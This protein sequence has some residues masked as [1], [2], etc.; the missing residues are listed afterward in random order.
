MSRTGPGGPGRVLGVVAGALAITAVAA[1]AAL[2]GLALG[3]PPAPAQETGEAGAVEEILSYDVRVEVGAGGAL[4]VTEALEVRALGRQIRRGIYR[5][6]PTRF[7][8]E[9]GFGTVVAPFR[10]VAV[11]RDG[12][13]ERHRLESVEGPA[14]RSGVRIRVGREDVQLSR[15]VHEYRIVYETARWL[16]FGPE[17]DRLEWNVTGNGWAFPIREASAAVELPGSPPADGVELAAWT[18]PAGSREQDAAWGWDAGQGRARFRTTAP[19]DAREGLT[20]RVDV[21][22][23]VIP[24][25]SEAQRAAWFRLDWGGF[26]DAALV[27]G[28]LLAFYLLM[29]IRVGRDPASRATVVRYEPPDGFSA[30]AAGFLRERGFD[31][32]QATAAVVSLAVKGAVTIERDGRKWRIRDTGRSPDGLTPDEEA[33]RRE[34]LDSSGRIVLEGAPSERVRKAVN[35]LRKRLRR[36]LEKEY[37]LNNRGWFAAG[38][39]VSLAG[40]GALGW[41]YRFGVGPEGWF[42]VLWL[43]FWTIG[44]AALLVRAFQAWR[45]ALTSG[46]LDWVGAIFLTGF[47]VPFVGAELVVGGMLYRLMPGHVVAA[48]IVVGALNVLFY[49]LLERPT[50][51]GRGVLDRLE[52]FRRFLGATEEGRMNRLQRPDRSLELFERFLPYAIAL[53]VQN[54]WAARFEGAVAAGTTTPS[55]YGGGGISGPAGVSSA[56]GGSL[57]SSLSASSASPSSGGGGAGGSSGGGGGGGGGGGW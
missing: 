26:R 51:K 46:G 37:F 44:V 6:F 9:E 5:D 39:A 28:L 18:G 3:A 29:W 45:R 25:P 16:R 49:H 12:R 20:V 21:P 36:R 33:L 13:P 50:M 40:L 34:L 32:A 23:G 52:G 38:L 43:A 10:V 24:P 42:L 54:E 57:S 1:L 14:G 2:A 35:K 53:G 8:R 11:E 55:W 15:G 22:S 27:A 31:P 7:P 4:R 48:A 41:R 30:A 56:V 47:S 19:L 17:R